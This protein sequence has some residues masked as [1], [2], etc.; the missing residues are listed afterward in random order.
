[1]SKKLIGLV[2]SVALLGAGSALANNDHDK[3]GSKD[4]QGSDVSAQSSTDTTRSPSTSSDMGMQ[5]SSSS[6]GDINSGVGGSGT[7]GTSSSTG[8]GSTGSSMGS[9]D[10]MAQDKGMHDKMMKGSSMGMNDQMSGN[11]LAGRV[12]RSD[13]KMVYIEDK[14]GAVVP[15]RIDKSTQFQGTSLKSSR[16]IKAGQEIRASFT[17]K[18]KTDNVAT[19]IWSSTDMNQGQGGSGVLDTQQGLQGDQNLND[20][21]LNNRDLNDRTLNK[22]QDLNKGQNLNDDQKLQPGTGGSGGFGTDQGKD[23]NVNPDSSGMNDSLDRGSLNNR[24]VNPGPLNDPNP[25][26]APNRD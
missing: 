22:D 16:D 10:T 5:G 17:V 6:T 21:N 19:K 13:A 3:I 11:E 4:V 26:L 8:M 9:T 7:A 2:A 18:N 14:L 1:M 25:G 24:T 15:L 23:I 20:R 12:V